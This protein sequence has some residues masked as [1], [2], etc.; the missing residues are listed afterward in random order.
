MAGAE[1]LI[2]ELVSFAQANNLEPVVFIVNNYAIEYYDAVFREMRVKVIRSRLGSIKELRSPVN[3]AR[4]LYWNFVLKYLASKRYSSVQVIGLYNVEKVY[5][6]V[7]HPNRV[8]WHVNN[9]AQHRDHK[10]PFPG[11][12]FGNPSDTVICINRYQMDELHAQYG[13]DQLR[14]ALK[15]FKLFTVSYD[16]THRR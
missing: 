14:A 11:M 15:V 4:A 13:P 1:R 8:F 5:D 6:I 3:I 16:P 7:T 9:S 2:Y 10:Y 12:I